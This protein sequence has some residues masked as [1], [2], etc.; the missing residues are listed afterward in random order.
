M[1]A[2]ND[3]VPFPSVLPAPPSLC[4]GGPGRN[5]PGPKIPK[6]RRVILQRMTVMQYVLFSPN[7][8]PQFSRRSNWFALPKSSAVSPG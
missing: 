3:T 6:P 4:L 7:G 2:V 5:G 8:P 1:D